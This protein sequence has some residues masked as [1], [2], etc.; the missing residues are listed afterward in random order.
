MNYMDF[1]GTAGMGGDFD[2]IPN[3]QLAF[4][5]L[6]VRGVKATNSGGAYI[7]CELTIDE[8]QPYA[9][10]K[11]WEMIGD[12][13]NSGNSEKYRQMGS[14]AITRILEAGRGAGPNN[15]DGY[16]IANYEQLSGLRVAIKVGIEPGTNGHDDKNRVKDFLTPN[17]ASQSGHKGWQ[18]LIAGNFNPNASSGQQ[19]GGQSQGGF[20]G[21]GGGQP[22]TN[23][24]PQGGGFGGGQTAQT[25][26]GGGFGGGNAQGGNAAQGGGFG[27]GQQ[28]GQAGGQSGFQQAAANTQGGAQNAG[29]GSNTTGFAATQT[30]TDQSHS[31]PG[32]TPAWLQ[33]AGQGAQS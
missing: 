18:Q 2:V 26:T 6:S 33:Q 24:Q 13:N 27:G 7:D 11:V 17:P 25:Q 28:G 15:P 9:G 10:R 3:G 32:A 14:I 4:A 8:G 22:Q 21:F 16:K 23:G 12:P 19:S 30:A 29:N 1:S 20:G 31:D 5:I